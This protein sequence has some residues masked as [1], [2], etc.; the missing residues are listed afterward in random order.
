[1]ADF[2][3]YELDL[4][5]GDAVQVSLDKQAN[6]RLLDGNNFQKYRSGQRHTYHG[7]LA[8]QSPVV[9]RPPHSGRWHVVID[10]GGNSG[11]IRASVSVV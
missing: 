11:N 5:A 6:V 1:M 8:K 3:H 9:I 2:L 4:N 7:G 10:L